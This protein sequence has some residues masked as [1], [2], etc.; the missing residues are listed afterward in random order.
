MGYNANPNVDNIPPNSMVSPSRNVNIHEGGIGKRGGTAHVDAAAMTDAP[1]IMGIF[2]YTLNSGTQY[3][4]RATADGKL[5]R[6]DTNTIK[7][8]LGTSKFSSFT[9]MNNKLYA[10]N[11]YN[12][13][14]VWD[15]SSI[16]D[17]AAPSADWSS[18]NHPSQILVH[19][20]SNSERMWAL[21]VASKLNFLYY[22]VDNDGAS[23]A[24]FSGAGSGQLYIETGDGSGLV[25]MVEYQDRLFAFS[26]KKSFRVVDDD[27]TPTNWAYVEAGWSG[28]A[29]HNRLIIVTP[30]DIV[31]MTEDGEV[32]SVTAAQTYGDYK[33]ASLS[34]PA[35]IHKYIKDNVDLAY[36]N[37]FHM[38]YDPVLRVINIYVVKKGS[39]EVNTALCYFIDR[40]PDKAWAIK[41]NQTYASGWNASTSALIRASAGTYKIYTGDYDGYLWELETANKN[42]NSNGYYA[43]I[44]IPYQSFGNHRLT[45]RYDYLRAVVKPIGAYSLTVSVSIDGS[46]SMTGSMSMAGTGSTLGTFVLGTD[47]LGGLD[48]IDTELKIG[49]RGRRINVELYNSNAD[50]DFFI[51]QIMFDFKPLGVRP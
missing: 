47:V 33:S 39:T 27:A 3:I 37:D 10:A 26:K 28:G 40:S 1:R 21:G 46:Q 38:I 35:F 16:I 9:V 24:N 13:I 42:D 8:G 12:I 45:K 49:D 7:T 6:D 19:G 11:G 36:I 44:K 23:N 31:A 14:Q 18:T 15:G 22:S 43:G 50:Q 48:L 4:I 32:Y 41:D 25:G 30:N 29:A 51:S 20:N 5:Y 2:D 34:R 17:L